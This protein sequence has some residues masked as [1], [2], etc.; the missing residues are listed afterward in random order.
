MIVDVAILADSR[1]C[2][3]G[4]IIEAEILATITINHNS[5]TDI[6]IL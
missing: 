6:E 1:S 5:Y 2:L 4:S 3:V